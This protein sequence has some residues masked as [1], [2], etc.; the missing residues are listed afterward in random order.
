MYSSPGYS[1]RVREI[2]TIEAKH[3]TGE[4]NSIRMHVVEQ[5]AGRALAL[6]AIGG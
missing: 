2:T 5:R 6:E 1:D 4:T 3:R